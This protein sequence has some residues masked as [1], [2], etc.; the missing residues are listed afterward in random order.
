[1]GFLSGKKKVDTERGMLEMKGTMNALTLRIRRLESRMV[2]EQKSA[3]DAMAKGDRAIARQ[4][5]SIVVD[6]ENRRTRYQQQYL[7]LETALMNIEEAKDQAE[8]LRAFGIANEALTEARSLLS[9]Q[10]IQ[11]QLDRLSESFEH[12]SIAGDLLSED[13]SGSTTTLEAEDKI[14]RQMDALEAEILLEKEGVLPPLQTEG[15]VSK[16]RKA[17]ADEKRV[18]KMLTDLEEEAKTEREKESE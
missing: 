17:S 9:P 11:I 4:H 6:L 7:T 15:E 13:L 5:L 8:V 18:D 14:E 2:E 1:M 16:E 10:E 3:K 12:I